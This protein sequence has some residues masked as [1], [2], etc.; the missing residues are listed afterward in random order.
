[1]ESPAQQMEFEDPPILVRVKLLTPGLQRDTEAK[2]VR[3]PVQSHYTYTEHSADGRVL[4]SN[5]SAR[6]KHAQ[7][8][9]PSHPLPRTAR[10]STAVAC[11]VWLWPV[12]T[13][14]NQTKR[15]KLYEKP[16]RAV[17]V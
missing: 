12:G 17:P 15:Q 7:K 2:L 9:F 8:K 5:R 14:Q 4:G 13:T 6:T 3:V 10:P 11:G 16:V 1:M